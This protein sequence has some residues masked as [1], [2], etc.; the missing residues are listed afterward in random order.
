MQHNI[1]GA[2]HLKNFAR[3]DKTFSSSL[4]PVDATE[5]EYKCI[6]RPLPTAIKH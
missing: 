3:S 5:N 1:V 2:R 6:S 4:P